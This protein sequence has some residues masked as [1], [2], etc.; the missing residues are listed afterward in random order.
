MMPYRGIRDRAALLEIVR[1]LCPSIFTNQCST[2]SVL[3][4][5]DFEIHIDEA[6]LRDEVETALIDLR[7]QWPMADRHLQICHLV[8]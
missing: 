5:D 6:I 4:T 3:P 2:W 1:D 7:I 8:V